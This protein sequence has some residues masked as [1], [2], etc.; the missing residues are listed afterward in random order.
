MIPTLKQ[1]DNA[2]QHESIGICLIAA[3]GGDNAYETMLELGCKK[4][5]SPQYEPMLLSYWIESIRSLLSSDY[6]A[7]ETIAYFASIGIEA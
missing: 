3:N 7:P 5:H 1:L 2:T 6:H 4:P